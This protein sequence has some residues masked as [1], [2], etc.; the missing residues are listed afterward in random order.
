MLFCRAKV[1][2]IEQYGTIDHIRQKTVSPLPLFW[3]CAEVT[4]SLKNKGRTSL[5][6]PLLSQ[7]I[8]SL[9]AD[10]SENA[11]TGIRLRNT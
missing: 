10:R 9:A 4:V 5:R 6:S 3:G 2:H 11:P 7:V 1:L 8:Q